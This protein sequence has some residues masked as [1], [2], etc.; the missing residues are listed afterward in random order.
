MKTLFIAKG[1]PWENGYVESFNSRFR[2]ELLDRELF[3]EPG[4][5]PLVRR[6]LAA[7]LQSPPAAQCVG[8]P[9]PGGVRRSDH[10]EAAVSGRF[11]S[12]VDFV[13]ASANF[14]APAAQRFTI[15]RFP[16]SRW[17]IDRGKASCSRNSWATT[18]V[19]GRI[20]VWTGTVPSIAMWPRPNSARLSASPWSADC[21]TATPAPQRERLACVPSSFESGFMLR[22]SHILAKKPAL[23]SRFIRASSDS[24]F[25]PTRNLSSKTHSSPLGW[26]FR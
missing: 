17:S 2:D 21:I 9:N 1:S 5:C 6:S 14:S 19:R 24:R 26:R 18:T 15:S 22:T 3:F 12:E 4:G 16:H 25:A 11:R 8:V 7:G 20:K 10:R 23:C 13:Y